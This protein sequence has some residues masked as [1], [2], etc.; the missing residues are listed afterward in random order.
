M[1]EITT[2]Y[3]EP[4]RVNELHMLSL[5]AIHTASLIDIKTK[6]KIRIIWHEKDLYD[7]PVI[8]SKYFTYEIDDHQNV[9]EL[10]ENYF[11]DLKKTNSNIIKPGDIIDIPVLEYQNRIKIMG[12]GRYQLYTKPL[13]FENQKVEIEPYLL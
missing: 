10:A 11:E 8:K 7:L 6:N 1:Y 12:K 3:H 9:L 5:K 4:F 2:H 13:L